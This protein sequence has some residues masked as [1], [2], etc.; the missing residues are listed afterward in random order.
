MK[1][2]YNCLNIRYITTLLKDIQ[3]AFTARDD[4]SHNIQLG[5]WGTNNDYIFCEYLNHYFSE[6]LPCERKALMYITRAVI[7]A[8]CEAYS[9]LIK[10]GYYGFEEVDNQDYSLNELAEQLTLNFG[11]DDNYPPF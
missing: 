2:E 7:N 8:S 5:E 11:E 6:A 3:K 1:Q 9:E 10:E 4:I